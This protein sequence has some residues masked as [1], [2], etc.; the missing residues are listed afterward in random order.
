MGI[1]R[2]Q[3]EVDNLLAHV[4]T[5][6]HTQAGAS[7]F[8]IVATSCGFYS[9]DSQVICFRSGEFWRKPRLLVAPLEPL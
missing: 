8:H 1:S 6:T 4:A 9:R 5:H 7:T 2:V 3:Q